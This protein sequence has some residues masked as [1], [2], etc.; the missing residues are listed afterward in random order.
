MLK[1]IVE[2]LK[3]SAAAIGTVSGLIGTITETKDKFSH[4]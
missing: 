2:V 4:A 1:V 3:F